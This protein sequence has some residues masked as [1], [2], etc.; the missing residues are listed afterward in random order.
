MALLIEIITSLNHLKEIYI[1][2]LNC[3]CARLRACMRVWTLNNVHNKN[4]TNINNN[5]FKKNI[6]MAQAASYYAARFYVLGL[7]VSSCNKR[8]ERDDLISTLG[9]PSV[10]TC[11]KLNK[12]II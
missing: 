2:V 1:H 6:S 7:D 3:G 12:E 11:L 5:N 10:V 8:L 9:V 4:N